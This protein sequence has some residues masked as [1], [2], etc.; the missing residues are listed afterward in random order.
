MEAVD[1]VGAD[2]LEAE[3]NFGNAAAE[4]DAD[5]M[6]NIGFLAGLLEEPPLAVV[7]IVGASLMLPKIPP[8]AAGA[9]A[10]VLLGVADEVLRVFRKWRNA[11]LLAST[12]RKVG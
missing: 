2:V 7:D 6:A 10:E 4:E 11:A 12:Q 1:M 5:G 8:P 9:P 3:P